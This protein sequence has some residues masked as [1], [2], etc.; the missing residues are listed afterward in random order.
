MATYYTARIPRTEDFRRRDLATLLNNWSGELDRARQFAAA[1]KPGPPPKPVS[2]P[3]EVY[4][5]TVEEIVLE[6]ER[7]PPAEQADFWRTARDK[8][9]DTPRPPGRRPVVDEA[10]DVWEFRRKM[11]GNS[12]GPAR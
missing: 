5:A 11:D 7:R 4:D 2:R 12:G 9:R 3:A 6:A 1:T 10:R 8:W